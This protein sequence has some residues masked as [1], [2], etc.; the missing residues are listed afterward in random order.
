M[1]GEG[2]YRR[3]AVELARTAHSRFTQRAHGR[4]R[5]CWKM[6][7]DLSRP[8]VP[9]MGHHDPLD[10]LVTLV[11]LRTTAKALGTAA[12]P[13][14]LV[15]DAAGVGGGV[16][17][18]VPRDERDGHGGGRYR[19]WTRRCARPGRR[20]S[21]SRVRR[22]PTIAAV[23]DTTSAARRRDLVGH[24][25][26]DGAA[27]DDLGA[28]TPLAGL[29]DVLGARAGWRVLVI[30]AGSGGTA[31]L[32]ADLVG[33]RGAVTAVEADA[34]VAVAARRA[35]V[36]GRVRAR[37]EVGDGVETVYLQYDAGIR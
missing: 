5:M 37:V 31:T 3:W 18:Q 25:G 11:Q 15:G 28:T 20:G 22:P 12:E 26:T 17:L 34:D 6:S 33:D 23:P 2:R 19:R 14:Q 9:S 10:G 30:G 35:L 13:P 4:P 1:T 7:I 27:R 8:L 16:T 24:L 29:H 36:S 21:T 32:L